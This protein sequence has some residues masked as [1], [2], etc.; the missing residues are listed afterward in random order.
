MEGQTGAPGAQ[1]TTAELE[2]AI[3]AE[4]ALNQKQRAA[5]EGEVL[6]P[7]DQ[8]GYQ[9][10]ARIDAQASHNENVQTIAF[11]VATVFEIVSMVK[12]RPHWKVSGEEALKTADPITRVIEKHWPDAKL[13][14]EIEAIAAVGMLIFSRVAIDRAL[15]AQAKKQAEADNGSQAQ[16]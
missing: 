6:Q 14:V 15:D 1:D 5:L 10:G 2:A 12:E 9:G 4:Q 13:A 16:S 8:S 11:C 7:G 3:A